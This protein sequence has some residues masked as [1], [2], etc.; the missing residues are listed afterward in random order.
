MTS[1]KP[2]VDLSKYRNHQRKFPWGLIRKLIIAVV[3]IGLVYYFVD[4]I[5][6]R[7][8]ERLKQEYNSKEIEVEVE[9]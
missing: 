2:K 9:I 1:K 8:E 5:E 4:I 7:N 6:K 3:I